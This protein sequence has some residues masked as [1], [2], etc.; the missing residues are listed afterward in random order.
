MNTLR[1]VAGGDGG[2]VKV[3]ADVKPGDS[4]VIYCDDEGS[5]VDACTCMCM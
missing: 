3:H 5:K 4:I 1:S 2:E